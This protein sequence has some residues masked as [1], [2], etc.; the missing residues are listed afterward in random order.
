MRNM[1]ILVWVYGTIV[2]VG[3]LIGWLKARS[4]PSLLSG[5]VFGVLLWLCGLGMWQG[6]RFGLTVAGVLALVLALVMG[7][8]FVKT[9]KFM[10]SGLVAVLSAVVFVV[11]VIAMSS[12]S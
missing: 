2:F 5:L 10:P 1:A 8:R 4:T 7:T 3:G 6:Q 9:K 12:A 11:L